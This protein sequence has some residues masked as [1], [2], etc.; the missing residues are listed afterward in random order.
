MKNRYLSKEIIILT[1]ST[2][3]CKCTTGVIP[4]AVYTL[5][6]LVKVNQQNGNQIENLWKPAEYLLVSTF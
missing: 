4:S 1:S 5:K 6:K 3:F 2:Y